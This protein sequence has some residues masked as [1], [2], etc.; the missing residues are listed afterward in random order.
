[1]RR[2]KD[3]PDEYRDA[4]VTDNMPPPGWVRGLEVAL[5]QRSDKTEAEIERRMSELQTRADE[6]IAELRDLAP[7]SPPPTMPDEPEKLERLVR[8]LEQQVRLASVPQQHNGWLGHRFVRR[9]ESSLQVCSE[10]NKT[11][12]D[13]MGRCRGRPGRH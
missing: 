11:R 9:T 10:C 7:G 2:S 5:P 13:A 4:M 12:S 1:M 8:Q 3:D 6:L